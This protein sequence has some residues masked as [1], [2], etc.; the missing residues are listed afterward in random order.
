MTE[1]SDG[2]ICEGS[3]VLFCFEGEDFGRYVGKS[4]DGGS[5]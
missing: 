3:G 2:A 4:E 5:T 1:F